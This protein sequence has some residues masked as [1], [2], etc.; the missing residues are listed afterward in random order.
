MKPLKYIILSLLSACVP[1]VHADTV[2]LDRTLCR[3]MALEHSEQLAIA[4]NE[5]KR[6]ELDRK[7]AGTAL[8]PK[9]DG[10]ATALYMLPDIDMMGSTL[11]VRGMYMAGIQIVQPIYT[12]GKI[13][14]GRKLAGIGRKV[15]GEQLRMC[16]MDII[17]DADNSY[18][19]YVAVLDKVSLVEAFR[20]M[21][22]TLYVQTAAA[23]EAGM[24]IEN[25][26]LRISARQSDLD[27]QLQKARNGAELC[28]IALCNTI[29]VSADTHIEI[30]RE[31]PPA[32]QPGM[33]STDISARPEVRLLENQVEA[34]RQ[35][36]NLTRSD[37][38]PTVGLSL[39]YN[40]YGNIKM[41]GVA[42]L[43]Q[44]NY[45]P[46]K[47]EY[48]D[49]I[50]MGVLSVN[51]PLF[52]WGEGVKKVRKA[53][54]AV[55]NARLDLADKTRLMDLE[56]RQS[57]TN[58][59]DGYNMIKAAEKSLSQAAENL[60]VMQDRYDESLSP[61]TDLLDAQTQWHQARSSVIEAST[62]YQIY[63]TAWLRAT[64]QLDAD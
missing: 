31:I 12:G 34:A 33:L 38:L 35:Q 29:G 61:L 64:G 54:L 40:Y 55:D 36:V 25:D 46:F 48:R 50:A 6:A 44:G 1:A 10:S 22:D 16:R 13:T 14:A 60:R 49:G 32:E 63:R 20:S 53:R 37:F 7:I 45:V 56:A 11:Q 30:S 28:R 23:V 26:L 62:Q 51:I 19:T 15:A 58:L 2:R 17:A 3:Q 52:H 18:W 47:Q 43:G 9:L 21:I 5:V 8:L 27:Y 24:A 59:I 42:D 41:K 57:V 39:G 4:E